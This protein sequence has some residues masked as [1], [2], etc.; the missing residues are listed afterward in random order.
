M[1]KH[2]GNPC[3]LRLHVYFIHYIYIK[4]M[5]RKEMKRHLHYMCAQK[6][7]HVCKKQSIYDNTQATP[8]EQEYMYTL[9]ISNTNI[10]NKN[11]LA[12]YL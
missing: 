5:K 7:I 6:K 1:Y 3:K 11:T 4:K 12:L 2:T 8:A 9:Y 10:G